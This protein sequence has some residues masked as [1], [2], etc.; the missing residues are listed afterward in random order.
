MKLEEVV[1][2]GRS[3]WEYRRL[4]VLGE[5]ELALPMVSVADGPI[6]FNAERRSREVAL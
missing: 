1:P 5:A 2:L 3:L 6:G 4:F